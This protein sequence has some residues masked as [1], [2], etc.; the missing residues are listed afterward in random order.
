MG[1][2]LEVLLQGLSFHTRLISEY[3][4]GEPEE[5]LGGVQLL[6]ATPTVSTEA[7]ARFLD[8]MRSAPGTANMPVLTLSTAPK[9]EPT[10]QSGVVLWPC[11]LEDLRMEIEAALLT[12]GDAKESTRP[13]SCSGPEELEAPGPSAA[14]PS[15]TAEAQVAQEGVAGSTASPRASCAPDT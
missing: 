1:R 13:G 8:S 5:V 7:R 3:G 4:A 11:R 10:D 14:S 2:A 12:A 15:S 6:L 9:K